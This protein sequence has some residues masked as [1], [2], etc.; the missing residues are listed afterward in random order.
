M[1]ICY[2][3]VGFPIGWA[4]VLGDVWTSCGPL[5]H[6]AAEGDWALQFHGL[7]QGMLCGPVIMEFLI[8]LDSLIVWFIFSLVFFLKSHLVGE[9]LKRSGECKRYNLGVF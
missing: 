7:M 9:V 1:H 8:P 2:K 4:Y 6:K 3:G 5:E